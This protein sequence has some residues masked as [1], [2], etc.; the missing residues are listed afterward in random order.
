MTLN[1]ALLH[2][3]TTLYEQVFLKKRDD[4]LLS[5]MSR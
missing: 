2:P 1:D 5:G 3:F 4:D